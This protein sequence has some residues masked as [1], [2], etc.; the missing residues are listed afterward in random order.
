MLHPGP[1]DLLV[2][3]SS[4]SAAGSVAPSTQRRG[5][6]RAGNRACGHA[7][8]VALVLDGSDVI[9]QLTVDAVGSAAALNAEGA[10][11]ALL[12]R[13]AE[14]VLALSHRRLATMLGGLP[15][16][17]MHCSVLLAEALR[18]AIYDCRSE[19]PCGSSDNTVACRCF[20]V[21]EGMIRRAVRLNG[22]TSLHEVT[23]YTHAAGGCGLCAE[24]VE[25]VLTDARARVQDDLM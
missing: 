4:G 15:E 25:A 5:V 11:A 8:R 19:A 12:G 2:P 23:R 6:G 1:L 20:A 24:E 22:L 14:D 16:A 21:A 3:A 17:E 7:L 9:T 18:A 10:R 13:A